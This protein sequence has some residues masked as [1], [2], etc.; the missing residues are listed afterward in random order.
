MSLRPTPEGHQ[1]APRGNGNLDPRI[2]LG[3]ALVIGS[4]AAYFVDWQTAFQT[5]VVVVSLFTPRQED[6]PVGPSR[7]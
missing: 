7:Q 3:V 5:F 6:G 1:P 4:L 2:V